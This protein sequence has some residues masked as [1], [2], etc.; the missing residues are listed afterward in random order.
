ML[1]CSRRCL[2]QRLR[3]VGMEFSEHPYVKGGG[4][5]GH[6]GGPIVGLRLLTF[7]EKDLT[8]WPT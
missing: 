5:V 8:N 2:R 4:K 6:V 1:G 7:G 3:E